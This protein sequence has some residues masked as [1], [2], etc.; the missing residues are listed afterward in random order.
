MLQN[1]HRRARGGLSLLC[2]TRWP[3]SP[4]APAGDRPNKLFSRGAGVEERP[5]VSC[6]EKIHTTCSSIKRPER[7]EAMYQPAASM[8]GGR[9]KGF[10]S[11][12]D[13]GSTQCG[14]AVDAQSTTPTKPPPA[15]PPGAPPPH[16][17]EAL[18]EA[19]YH[20][21]CCA[22]PSFLAPGFKG[23]GV[24]ASARR[25]RRVCLALP[26]GA[27]STVTFQRRETLRT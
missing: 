4:P 20:R 5:R 18:C 7:R 26:P 8:P 1:Y 17:S 9:G 10:F 22:S 25:K 3:T 11:S 23:A 13:D 14:S 16:P 21:I 6:G 2:Q 27:V 24:R 19:R 12:G 15:P